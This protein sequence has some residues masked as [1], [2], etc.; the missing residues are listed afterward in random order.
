MIAGICILLIIALLILARKGR[1]GHKGLAALRGWSYAHR[2]LHG[3]GVPENSMA[4]F[5]KALEHG[6]GIELDVHLM[7]DGTL[8]VIHD[9]SL[10][11]TA[12]V[13]VKIE[14]LTAAEL[15]QYD[16]EGTQEKIPLFSQVLELFD[17]KAPM[18]IELK[19]EKGNHGALCAAVCKLLEDYKGVYCIESFDPRCVL[20]LKKNRP[21]VIRGQLSR[22]FFREKKAKMPLI[23]KCLLSWNL[24][25]ILT[26]PDFLSYGYSERKLLSVWL[27]K[28]LW[29]V[30]GVAWTIQSLE[31]HKQAEREGWITIFENFEPEG[32]S[33]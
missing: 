33:V 5:R 12:G 2:G 28:N 15:E 10:L 17:G 8:A 3:A 20:W 6:Y 31:D 14:D 23:L 26:Y 18:I 19:A 16:L 21:E 30:Q 11:R 4:A 7:R 24:T 13:D 29:K 9:A 27:C 1:V 32:H 25:T 22:N